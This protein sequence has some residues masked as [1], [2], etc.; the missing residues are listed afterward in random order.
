MVKKKINKPSK[1]INKR[2]KRKPNLPKKNVKKKSGIQLAVDVGFA[3]L[4]SPEASHFVGLCFKVFG[5]A[6]CQHSEIIKAEAKDPLKLLNIE[7][8]EKKNV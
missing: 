7:Q 6:L 8:G 5:Q 3:I 2:Y 4:E 1:V